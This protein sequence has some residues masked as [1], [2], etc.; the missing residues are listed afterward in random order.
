MNGRVGEDYITQRVASLTYPNYKYFL[1]TKI[2]TVINT[3]TK[4]FLYI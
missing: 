2:L 3:R 1:L 4:Q